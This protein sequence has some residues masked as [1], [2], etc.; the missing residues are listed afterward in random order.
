MTL[1]MYRL[2]ASAGAWMSVTEDIKAR[3][4][5]VNYLSQYINLKK[6]GRNYTAICPFHAEKTPSFVVFPESQ[7][8]KCFG[9]CGDG[10]DIFNFVMK[11]EGLDFPTALRT[12]ADKAG[13]Q[14]QER[15]P[16]QS[17]EEDRLDKMRGLL[18]ETA[19][20][21]HKKL[22][23]DK[24]A[25]TAREYAHKRGLS[26]ETIAN[27]RIGYAPDDWRQALDYLMLLGYEEQAI[28]E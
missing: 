4:D 13:V 6:A 17:Q 3:L 16:E 8:W 27:F 23:N 5:I 21:F 14:L 19:N 1:G 20:F 2:L 12:L 24:Q 22:L 11:Q 15:T 9:A 26:D 7:T 28:I 10:G 18:D 25:K